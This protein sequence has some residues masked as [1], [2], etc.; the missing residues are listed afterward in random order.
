MSAALVGAQRT[1]RR[2]SSG[3]IF[4]PPLGSATR[5]R[6]HTTVAVHIFLAQPDRPRRRIGRVL[7]RMILGT[8]ASAHSAPSGLMRGRCSRPAYRGHS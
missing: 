1:I 8:S 5:M 2:G 6:Q 7:E 4:Q 3:E